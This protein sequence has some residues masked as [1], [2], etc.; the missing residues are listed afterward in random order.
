MSAH[1]LLTVQ[2]TSLCWG[3]R[4]QRSCKGAQVLTLLDGETLPLETLPLAA[5]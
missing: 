4:G 3:W 5:S 2:Q 1:Q